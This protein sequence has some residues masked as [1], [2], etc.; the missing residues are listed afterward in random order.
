MTTGPD[1]SPDP[2]HETMPRSG[3]CLQAARS[4]ATYQVLLRSR[5]QENY[6][7]LMSPLNRP[8]I[9]H[10][11]GTWVPELRILS[12][13]VDCSCRDAVSRIGKFEI[14][15]GQLKLFQ[16]E[17]LTGSGCRQP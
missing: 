9:D 10:S 2:T 4:G 8:F 7:A 6:T 3:I 14:V 13:E 11:I 17:P 15:T 5:P 16:D 12:S 1:A